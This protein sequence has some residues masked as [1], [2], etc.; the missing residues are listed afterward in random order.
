MHEEV[1][2]IFYSTSEKIKRNLKEI[3]RGEKESLFF[4]FFIL[5]E[6][7]F[8][9]TKNSLSSEKLKVAIYLFSMN[10]KKISRKKIHFSKKKNLDIN[11]TEV[12]R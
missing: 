9:F 11:N 8:N 4:F 10:V 2:S 1:H 12:R 6:I 3:I 5:Q 7:I